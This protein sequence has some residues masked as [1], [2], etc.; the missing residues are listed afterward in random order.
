[1]NLAEFLVAHRSE[2]DDPALWHAGGMITF[3]ELVDEVARV[4][5]GMRAAGVAPG[6]RVAVMDANTATFVVAH[7]AALW[8]GAV[9]VPVNPLGARDEVRRELEE[10]EPALLVVGA[11]GMRVAGEALTAGTRVPRVAVAHGV[12]VAGSTVTWADLG[13]AAPIDPEPRGPDDLAVLLFTA[14]T[15]G[16]PKAAMLSHG[17]LA[18]NVEQV[19]THPA[20]A[21]AATD[22]GLGLLPFFHV[23]GLNVVLGLSLRAG[24]SV[25][26]LDGFDPPGSIEAI[27]RH[28]I[29][30]V[31]AVPPVYAAW[32]RLDAA[33]APPDAFASVRLA[34]S[35]AA[36]LVESIAAGMRSRFG[37]EV[38]DGYGLT[39]ASPAVTTTALGGAGARPGSIGPPI[40]GVAV[41]LVDVDGEDALIGD[42]GEIW[43]RGPNVFAGY[44]RDP[45]QT[46]EV[47]TETG[48]LRTGDVATV[49]DDGYLELVGRAKDLI[50]VNGFNVYPAEV[51]DVLREHSDVGDVAVLGQ[52]SDR[53]GEQVVAYIVPTPGRTPDPD[54]LIE[55]CAARLARYKRPAR[56][57]I[58]DDLPRSPV[59]KVLRRVLRDS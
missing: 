54:E 23:F 4:A 57:E 15:A 46:A 29:T 27:R 50:I 20:L 55:F 10:T 26:L 47:L 49:D 53:T 28:R 38:H 48:W 36:A 42:P 31:A 37:V 5:G 34:V 33:E 22:I 25:V 19:Q 3:R 18:A 8:C 2:S 24:A 58:V 56:I 40:P 44:W 43:V 35:G 41:R 14:G 9:S 52:P 7:L 1:M 12:T 32:L 17:N 30:V 11:A 51:E 39:E 59:G 13:A 21:L 16:A 6:D 45:E